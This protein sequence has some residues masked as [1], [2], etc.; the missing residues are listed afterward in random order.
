M[1][2]TWKILSMDRFAAHG[3]NVDVVTNVFWYVSDSDSDGKYGYCYGNT[4]LH[5]GSETFTDYTQLTEAQV[6]QWVKDD[7][8]ASTPIIDGPNE[9]TIVENC[10]TD[11]IGAG[12]FSLRHQGVPW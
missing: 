1:A 11:G 4:Q 5:S 12:T 7:L 10:V 9:L 3:G 2:L 6:V 8:A